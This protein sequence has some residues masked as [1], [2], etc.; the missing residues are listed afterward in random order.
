MVTFFHM[1]HIIICNK[2]GMEYTIYWYIYCTTKIV[3]PPQCL[4]PFCYGV[5]IIGRIVRG[6]NPIYM[7]AILF[8]CHSHNRPWRVSKMSI[9]HW[10]WSEING[11]SFLILN[12]AE[13]F[14]WPKFGAVKICFFSVSIH[15]TA[16]SHILL[17]RNKKSNLS[18]C[19]LLLF[20]KQNS[21]GTLTIT[22]HNAIAGGHRKWSS[23]AMAINEI[24]SRLQ[25]NIFSIINDKNKIFVPYLSVQAR[26][27]SVN[28]RRHQLNLHHKCS[29]KYGQTAKADNFL[30]FSGSILYY[31]HTYSNTLF[32]FV[33]AQ[34]KTAM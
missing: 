11:R 27:F 15:D 23:C 22:N 8:F 19:Y 29:L 5:W 2:K 20:C 13:W 30:P 1:P 9:V 3:L 24:W 10:I 32:V 17:C 21:R 25:Y 14:L 26:H 7:C 31:I 6:R 4:L 18:V 12:I 16:I 33:F 28:R 34:T